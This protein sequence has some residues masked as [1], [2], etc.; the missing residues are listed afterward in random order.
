[1]RRD[2]SLR[3][4]RECLL[5]RNSLPASQ[6]ILKRKA[7]LKRVGNSRVSDKHKSVK[8]NTRP[9]K[10][11]KNIKPIAG[12]LFFNKFI[13]TDEYIFKGHKVK[14]CHTI[15][16]LGIGGAQTMMFELVN[17]LNN[18]YSDYI[19]N[20][21]VCLSD[22]CKYDQ[23]FVRS[24]DINPVVKLSHELREFCLSNSIDVVVHHRTHTSKCIKVLLPPA[25]K[26]IL[27]NHTVNNL[28]AM[29]R[30]RN[31]DAYVSVCNFLD[32][33]TA[34]PNGIHSSRRFVILN[35]VEENKSDPVRLE[36]G[37]I[38]GR[39]HRLVR[40]KFRMDSLKWIDS[41]SKSLPNHVHYV[42]GSYK[43][44][45]HYCGQSRFCKYLGPINDRN[46]KMSIIKGF[47]V[48]FYDTYGPEG[49][50]VAILES[51]ASGVPVICKHYGGNTELIKH[52]IN[53]FV[54][55]DLKHFLKPLKSLQD[56]SRLCDMKTKVLEDFH[57]RLH[58]K[59][60]ACKYLQLI[61]SLVI[62]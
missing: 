61:E 32:Q 25:T 14:I 41:L 3:N 36:G 16:S 23:K 62:K 39:C 8:I 1:M 24:Y 33:K 37:F 45:K 5:R 35:G 57:K 29:S 6:R 58:I 52:G 22:S 30:F 51:L 31:C 17:G 48:Y 38:S 10:P 7:D 40:N 53:G 18:Y 49:A 19:D 11:T 44:A 15:D 54:V 21:V 56:Q 9:L 47:D 20:Y 26:Y 42:I 28:A 46:K 2:R 34:W 60:V 43:S 27:V 55:S 50:S 4:F 59:H 12:Q 13:D